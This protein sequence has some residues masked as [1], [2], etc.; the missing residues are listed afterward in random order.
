LLCADEQETACDEFFVHFIDGEELPA[1]VVAGV[2]DPVPDGSI[3]KARVP[4][5]VD[6]QVLL[7]VPVGVTVVLPDAHTVFATK[8]NIAITANNVINLFIIATLSYSVDCFHL[9][10]GRGNSPAGD[11]HLLYFKD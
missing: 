6:V 8:T 9:S 5:V 4:L 10:P 1:S 2:S 11:F 7:T 3:A